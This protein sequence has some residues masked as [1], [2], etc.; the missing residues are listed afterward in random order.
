MSKLNKPRA[1]ELVRSYGANPK[2][3]PQTER[4]AGVAWL[5]ENPFAAQNLLADAH[6]LDQVL[7]TLPAPARDTTLLQARV[8]KAAKNTA[9]GGAAQDGAAQDGAAQDGVAHGV[10]ANDAAP[11][12]RIS[13]VLSTWKA[14]AATLVFA[15][16]MG[17]GIGRV[18]AADTSYASA[19]ALLSMSMQS[20]Y[21]E[22]DLYG[23]G[24]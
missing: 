9:Q 17:F 14:V 8:L 18:A 2:R 21:V 6:S 10:A 5:D 20:D 11:A 19:E 12:P 4:Q 1:L 7:N 24:A 16:G 23:D 13:N 22:A 15:T 3:W